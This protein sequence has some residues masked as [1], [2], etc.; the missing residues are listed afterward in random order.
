MLQQLCV[1]EASLRNVRLETAPFASAL[2]LLG[3]AHWHE[4]STA[5]CKICLTIPELKICYNVQWHSKFHCN[6]W[7]VTAEVLFPFLAVLSLSASLT[8][9]VLASSG[10]IL[11]PAGTDSDMGEA[12]GTSLQKHPCSFSPS[13]TCPGPVVLCAST[14]DSTAAGQG[15]QARAAHTWNKAQDQGKKQQL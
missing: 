1:L 2:P 14:A 11:E 13:Q 12:S 10:S 15:S 6:I 3:I 5:A 7:I 9:S 4:D 8:G